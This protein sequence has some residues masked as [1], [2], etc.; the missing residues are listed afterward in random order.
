MEALT[1]RFM[2]VVREFDK[3]RGSG[4]IEAENG[5]SVS[6]RY[7]AIQGDG[8]RALQAGDRVTFDVEHNQRGLR[9]IHVNRQ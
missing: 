4:F 7:S 2:G 5:E 1:R 9:A 3:F 8:L 6:V